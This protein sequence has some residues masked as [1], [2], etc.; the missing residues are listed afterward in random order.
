MSGGKSG[1]LLF[2]L[3]P[4]DDAG[5]VSLITGNAQEILEDSFVGNEYIYR[6][7]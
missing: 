4:K 1:Y 2:V 3:Y 6:M 5:I 7:A